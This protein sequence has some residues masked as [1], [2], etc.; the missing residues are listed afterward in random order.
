[1]CEW[2]GEWQTAGDTQPV[3][4]AMCEKSIRFSNVPFG[5]VCLLMIAVPLGCARTHLFYD[6]KE[7]RHTPMSVTQRAGLEQALA[8]K[9]HGKTVTWVDSSG[10]SYALDVGARGF[11]VMPWAE[12]VA[13]WLA[14][15]G[16]EPGGENDI[17]VRIRSR[18]GR[19]DVPVTVEHDL[20]GHIV[21]KSAPDQA[22]KRPEGAPGAASIQKRFGLASRLPGRWHS[23]ER[24][25]LVEAL[26]ELSPVELEVVRPLGFE[27]HN[28]APGGNVSRAALY[29]R[30]GCAGT[31][32]LYASGVQTDRY[33]FVG[34][35]RKP[36][37][38]ALHS[39]V[40]EMG[41]AFEQ[42]L[43]RRAFCRAKSSRGTRAQA[44]H[45]LGNDWSDRNPVLDGY[46]QVLQGAPAPTDYGNSSPRESFAESFALFHVDPD[47]LERTRPEVFRWFA[48]GNH[49]QVFQEASRHRPDE[50]GS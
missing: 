27:R 34:S 15:T 30:Q 9:L 36:R 1:M 20:A 6:A 16:G 18:S 46:L 17:R 39:L 13:L 42:E 26:E 43:A 4:A 8:E 19:E 28:K 24:S 33:R 38:A 14:L 3:G 10:V 29:R 2:D 12:Q 49:I 44:W 40:H 23:S 47:A 32:I 5:A 7:L 31:I 35:V 50:P 22:R 48:E 45:K 37:N 25:A 21:V 11:R 41:H